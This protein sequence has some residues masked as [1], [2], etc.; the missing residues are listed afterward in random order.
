MAIVTSES[1]SDV[2]FK[3]SDNE[4]TRN[5][6]LINIIYDKKQ[7]VDSKYAEIVK[8]YRGIAKKGF[9]IISS[10]FS[11]HYYF[12]DELTLRGYLKNLSE[13]CIRGGYFIGTCYDGKKV[14]DEL[15]EKDKLEMIDSFGNKVYSIE[16][17]YNIEDFNYNKENKD[18]MFGQIINVYRSIGKEFPEYLVNFDLK[19]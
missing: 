1:I 18:N 8:Q 7:K 3:G 5:K 10:Q 13:N 11:F 4:I 6:Q 15:K 17:K 19:K 2:G 16:K 12:K 14:F 9:N